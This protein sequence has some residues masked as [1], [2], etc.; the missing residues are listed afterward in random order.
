ML[1]GLTPVHT[2]PMADATSAFYA[3][4]RLLLTADDVSV[5]Q[6][7][8][9]F[10]RAIQAPECHLLLELNAMATVKLVRRSPCLSTPT[11]EL[12]HP[13]QETGPDYERRSTAYATVTAWQGHRG[14]SPLLC[15][16]LY[17]LRCSGSPCS[18]PF[19]HLSLTRATN[20]HDASRVR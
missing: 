4:H 1:R 20:R 7:I 12:T 10:A 19:S 8:C 3:V 14:S 6:H 16:I 11:P 18:C 15:H 9:E 2:V 13:M 5:R 17:D